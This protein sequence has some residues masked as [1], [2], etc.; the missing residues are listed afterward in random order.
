M[1]TSPSRPQKPATKKHGGG[2]EYVLAVEKLLPAERVIAGP[3]LVT[4]RH[5][6][7]RNEEQGLAAKALKVQTQ[8][9]QK[10]R[11]VM[12]Q[13]RAFVVRPR[14]GW[15]SAGKHKQP[16]TATA[17]PM[18]GQVWVSK[19]HVKARVT[20]LTRDSID[21]QIEDAK[22]GHRNKVSPLSWFVKHFKQEAKA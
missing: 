5:Q 16:R 10:A 17:V 18:V 3:Y 1:K 21:Y 22:Q 7:L 4:H 6:Y 11:I 15:V 12:H 8:N 13:G 2:H 19:E 20:N 9:G 14:E